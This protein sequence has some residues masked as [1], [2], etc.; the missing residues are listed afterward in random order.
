MKRHTTH[1]V[2]EGRSVAVPRWA[3]GG[4]IPQIPR[5]VGVHVAP[6]LGHPERHAEPNVERRPL[7]SPV[8]SEAA[9]TAAPPSGHGNLCLPKPDLFAPALHAQVQ[10]FADVNLPCCDSRCFREGSDKP[11]PLLLGDPSWLLHNHRPPSYLMFSLKE[12]P[13]EMLVNRTCGTV[14]SQYTQPAVLAAAAPTQPA[15]LLSPSLAGRVPFSP[16]PG[17]HALVGPSPVS[18]DTESG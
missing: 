13:Q 14:S 6:C 10:C 15:C 5:V 4:A 16:P 2:Y 1:P 7:S 18:T 8:S 17:S 3:V 11:D 9:F 12:L